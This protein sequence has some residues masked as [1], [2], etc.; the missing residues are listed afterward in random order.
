[1]GDNWLVGYQRR[2]GIEGESF[3]PISTLSG[4]SCCPVTSGADALHLQLAIL[5]GTGSAQSGS[6]RIFASASNSASSWSQVCSTRHKPTDACAL[7]GGPNH[8]SM[9]NCT[10]ASVVA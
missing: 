9:L 4:H 5:I 7:L 6:G 2:A 1:M 8:R 10:S 3:G